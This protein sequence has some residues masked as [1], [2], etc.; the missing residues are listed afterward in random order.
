MRSREIR[1]HGVVLLI[2]IAAVLLAGC[3][4]STAKRT[5]ARG[6]FAGLVAIGGGRTMYLRCQGTGS[7]TVVLVSGLDSAADV[8]TGYQP[9]PSLAVSP[10]S[11]GSPGCA[12]MTGR[13][14]RSATT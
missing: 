1:W 5:P 4:T 11:H 7:P 8:W 6:D 12:P 3:G 2:A 14:H 9:D 10:G 13:A